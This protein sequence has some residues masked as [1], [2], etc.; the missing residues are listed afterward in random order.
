MNSLKKNYFYSRNKELSKLSGREELG[1]RDVETLLTILDIFRDPNN[2]TPKYELFKDK[3]IVD[4]GCGD[5]YLKKSIEFF[6]G[7]YVGLDIEDCNFESQNIN[8]DDQS[9]DFAICLA[10]I[11]HLQDPGNLMIEIKRILKK[12][13]H[14]IFSTPDI[15]AVKTHFWNDPT[16]VHPYNPK[17]IKTL[18]KMN[19]FEKIKVVPN[20]RCKSKLFYSENSLIF[21]ISRILPL[22][23]ASKIPFLEIIKGKC[24]GLFA[25]A[26]NN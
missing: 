18:L 5:Q 15:N 23:G 20:Y 10:L 19:G 4:I 13:S 24:S 16:H 8:L 21:F 22:K 12:K 3:K 2:K 6:G 7:D 26:M 14:V 11:E 25:L 17:S 1:K 9:F